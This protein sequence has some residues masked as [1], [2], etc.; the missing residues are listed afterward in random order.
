MRTFLTALTLPAL[1][2]GLQNIALADYKINSGPPG[3]WPCCPFSD[4]TLKTDVLQITNA[5]QTLLKIQGVTFNWK[6]GN[7][8]DV[9]VIAQDVQKVYPQLVRQDKQYLR[10]DYEKLVGP[11]IESVREMDARIKQL[12]A[13]QKTH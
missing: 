5:T 3:G 1:L 6:E 13:A 2:I 8:A 9:G 7:R 11:L 10:V 12:E 4:A